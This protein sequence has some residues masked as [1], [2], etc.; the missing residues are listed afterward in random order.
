MNIQVNEY[1]HRMWS[2][3][4][5]RFDVERIEIRES[6]GASRLAGVL[7]ADTPDALKIQPRPQEP[8]FDVIIPPGLNDMAFHGV[9]TDLFHRLRRGESLMGLD[10]TPP[11]PVRVQMETNW[12]GLALIGVLGVIAVGIVASSRN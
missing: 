7:R 12:G 10:Y 4:L 6:D 8:P 9:M 5:H 2:D 1:A 11:P 3:E